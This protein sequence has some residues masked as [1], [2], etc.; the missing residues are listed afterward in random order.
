MTHSA[1]SSV[2][3]SPRRARLGTM[4]VALA[5]SLAPLAVGCGLQDLECTASDPCECDGTGACEGTCVGGDCDMVC[6]GQGACEFDC[7]DG[8][9]VAHCKGQGT[10]ELS[11]PGGD[12]LMLCQGAGACELSD[13]PPGEC[14]L[15][16]NALGACEG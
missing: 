7:P 4:L 1:S 13:C 11:C 3:L 16:C 15:E 8:G 6:E 10:C 2:F 12:C 14:E 9:C 5:V